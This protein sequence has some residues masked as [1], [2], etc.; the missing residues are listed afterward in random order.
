MYLGRRSGSG[1]VSAAI[2]SMIPDSC[3][4]CTDVNVIAARMTKT[5]LEHHGARNADVVLCDLFT[6]FKPNLY[7]D[8]IVFN[9]PYVPTDEDEFDRALK[10]RDISASWAGGYQ[11]RRVID[12]FLRDFVPFLS[13]R[14]VLYLVV[15]D[16]NNPAQLEI[17]A[18]EM[19][20]QVTTALE[21]RAG[22][23][24]LYILRF[25]KN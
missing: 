12:K 14:G 23:E 24:K 18:R 22:M 5:T 21:R 1:E 17:T 20:L 2:S 11:G 9:P 10:T 19:G 8:L 13:T 25:L 15:L 3:C 16:A 4:L 7:F 6:A